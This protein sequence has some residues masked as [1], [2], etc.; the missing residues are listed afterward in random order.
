MDRLGLSVGHF[1]GTLPPPPPPVQIQQTAN[2]QFTR[3]NFTIELQE[4]FH[5]SFFTLLREFSSNPIDQQTVHQ[6][7]YSKQRNVGLFLTLFINTVLDNWG[8]IHKLFASWLLLIHFPNIFFYTHLCIRVGSTL[9]FSC[10]KS[11]LFLKSMEIRPFYR[12]IALYPWNEST[13]WIDS[14][15]GVGYYG[16]FSPNYFEY[17]LSIHNFNIF[18]HLNRKVA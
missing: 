9:L 2:L 5:L 15:T 13:L 18:I 11:Q 3:C 12:N 1:N 8:H 16:D 4:I 14:H 6:S 17:K 10:M 7:L